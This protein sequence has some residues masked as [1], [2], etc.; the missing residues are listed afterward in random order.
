MDILI[1]RKVMPDAMHV[2]LIVIAGSNA[3]GIV[4][5]L[6]PMEAGIY[7][8]ILLATPPHHK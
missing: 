5:A 2:I 8:A 1:A 4:M 6:V 3:F 7:I